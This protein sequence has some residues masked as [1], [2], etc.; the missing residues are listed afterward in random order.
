[1][2]TIPPQ[3]DENIR[4]WH[5]REGCDWL[6]ALPAAVAGLQ[7]GDT[8]LAIDGHQYE[9][10]G[11]SQILTELRQDAGKTVTGVGTVRS[12]RAP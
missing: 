2:V 11:E 6:A 5:G 7:S 8:I 12:E 10:F 1:M 3:L 4:S 9:F